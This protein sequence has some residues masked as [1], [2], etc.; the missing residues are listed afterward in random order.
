MKHADDAGDAD[1]CFSETVV[2][3]GEIV[4]VVGIPARASII[5]KMADI[6]ARRHTDVDGH[7][8]NSRDGWRHASG[9]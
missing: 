7:K 3:I 1:F 4:E 6:D 9:L 5:P 8:S 2:V